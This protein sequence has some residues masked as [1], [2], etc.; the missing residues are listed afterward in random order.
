MT[1]Y[2][3]QACYTD[4]EVVAMKGKYIIWGIV[5]GWVIPFMFLWPVSH[6]ENSTLP[7]ETPGTHTQPSAGTSKSVAV[8]QED[9]KVA[10][11]EAEEYLVGVVLGEIP[12]GFHTEALKAQAVVA[13]TF[14]YKAM[15]KRAKHTQADVCTDPGCCQAYCDPQTY[16]SNKGSS[17]HL[18][19][20]RNAVAQTADTVL[21]YN[22]ELIEA[23]Y[24]S[25][26]GGRTEDAVAVWG[27]DVP[28]LQSVESPG[29]EKASHY[30][31]TVHIPLPEFMTALALDGTMVSVESISYSR[32]GGVEKI[33]INGTEFTGGQMRSA[34]GLRSTAFVLTAL[35]DKVMITTR[36]FGHRVGMS[37]YGAQAMAEKGSDYPEILSH[38]FP[39]TELSQ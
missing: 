35:P 36:G 37:Q 38:Y 31:D 4:H 12:S 14:T 32:G 39:G 17:S 27:A 21:Y 23:T 19:A 1:K 34:L 18:S 22:G 10:V 20:V 11:M 26:S 9:G 24:F 25:C 5:L 33:I 6:Q 15:E 13:R 30:M 3:R 8:L 29:E 2:K 28:Y 16:L 7:T